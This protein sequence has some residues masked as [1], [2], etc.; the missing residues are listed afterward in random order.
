MPTVAHLKEFVQRA[1]SL[2]TTDTTESAL[3]DRWLND[4]YQRAVGL[5]GVSTYASETV[6]VT[7]GAEQ[8]LVA[9]YNPATTLGVVSVNGISVVAGAGSSSGRTLER[10]ALTDLASRRSRSNL[11][12][13]D[14]PTHYAVRGDGTIELFPQAGGANVFAVDV[15]LQPKELIATG[16]PTGTQELTPSAIPVHTH[17]EILANYAISQAFAYRGL[18][19][20]SSYFRSLYENGLNEL[21]AWLNEQGGIMGPRVQVLRRFSTGQYQAD[22]RW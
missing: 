16:T 5:T 18:S 2:N 15:E 12:T 9:D 7:D 19:D 4:A 13:M 1:A 11:N 10:I 14:G 6:T 17:Y 3:V 20:K 21:R 8:I 22:Q